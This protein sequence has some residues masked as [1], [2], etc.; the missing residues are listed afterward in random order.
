MAFETGRTGG[1]DVFDC[2]HGGR[3]GSVCESHCVCCFCE[4]LAAEAQGVCCLLALLKP[5]ADNVV[6]E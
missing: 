3:G 5:N 6:V 2:S 1:A 4:L